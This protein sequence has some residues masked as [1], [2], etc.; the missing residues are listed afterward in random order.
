[1]RVLN[2][3]QSTLAHLGVLAGHATTADAVADPRLAAF[4][5]AMLAGESIPT[6]APVPGTD[7]V[8]YLDQS[9][10]RIANRAIHHTCHQIATDGSQ[11]LPQ[12]LVNPAAERLARGEPSPRLAVAI[13]AWMAC[14]VRASDRFGRQWPVSDPEAPRVA[15]IAAHAGDD[16]PALVAGILALDTV[17]TPALAANAPFR[18]ALARA[19]AALLSSDPLQAI[20]DYR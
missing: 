10:A 3:A 19:L 6:L 9:F 14:L 7:P 13:A 16:A 5:R 4:T 15:A 20:E 18:A 11:K 17:F 12:R 2:A 8:A 1:M